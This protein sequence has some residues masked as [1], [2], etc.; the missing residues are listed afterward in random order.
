M[1]LP[2]KPPI[3]PMLAALADQIPAGPGW[4]YEPKWDGFRAIVF[5]E[6]ER[7]DLASRKGQPLERYFPELLT[8]LRDG[9]PERCV[10]DGEIVIVGDRGLDFD[11]LLQR[12]HPAASRI[13]LLA[14]QSPASFVAF[15]L[16]AL[17]DEDLRPLPFDRRR[18][19][20]ER[21]L[22][23]GPRLML[24]PQTSE[25]ELARE[26]FD[27]FEGA[28]LDG[29]VAKR[30]ELPYLP[31][32]RAMRWARCCSASTM[33]AEF[34]IT[35]GTRPPLRASS[36]GKF[37]R[38]SLRSKEKAASAEDE[39]R[40]NRVD[41]IRVGT[42]PGLEWR[43]SWCA[44]WRSIISKVIASDTPPASFAG[45]R[46]S[47]PENAPTSNSGRRAPFRSARCCA[48]P[49]VEDFSVVQLL[50][51]SPPASNISVQP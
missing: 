27:R 3:D 19:K 25:L 15:D 51:S 11:S 14:A 49:T 38:N 45:D 6:G 33:T 29:I 12:I 28:G 17:G 46:T 40:A 35:S 34:F 32:K 41:G 22:H 43:R 47:H 36:E 44:K 4:R 5:R 2:V 23:F 42:P 31:G 50:E 8:V 16:L 18:E 7:V 37:W 13:Q 10:V 48:R 26:W 20:L 1:S 21:S 30:A 9:L 39:R 24:A